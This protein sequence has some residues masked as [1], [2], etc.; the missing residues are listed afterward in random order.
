MGNDRTGTRGR[1][2]EISG[3]D[4]NGGCTVC[5]FLYVDNTNFSTC[6]LVQTCSAELVHFPTGATEESLDISGSNVL[7]C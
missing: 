6:E 2:E 4:E 1:N 5:N 3:N 7:S